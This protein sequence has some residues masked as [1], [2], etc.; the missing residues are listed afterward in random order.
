MYSSEPPFNIDAFLYPRPEI[1][2]GY[3]PN[4]DI[5]IFMKNLSKRSLVLARPLFS[6]LFFKKNHI[7]RKL[8]N[9]TELHCVH[10]VVCSQTFTIANFR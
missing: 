1:W 9:L 6:D 3:C 4:D 7:L 2:H 10:K 5:L 8:Q